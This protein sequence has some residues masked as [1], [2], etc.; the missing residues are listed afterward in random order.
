[1][2]EILDAEIVREPEKTLDELKIKDIYEHI[3]KIAITTQKDD[4]ALNAWTSILMYKRDTEGKEERMKAM[5]EM[6][7]N[8]SLVF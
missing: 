2:E 3:Y 4:V 6:C 8:M 7:K 5:Q 1:M